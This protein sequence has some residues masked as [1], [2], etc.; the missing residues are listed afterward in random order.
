MYNVKTI[1][2]KDA[3][4][5]VRDNCYSKLAPD[6]VVIGTYQN[7][8]RKTDTGIIIKEIKGGS[9][10]KGESWLPFKESKAIREIVTNGKIIAISNSTEDDEYVQVFE[11]PVKV[12]EVE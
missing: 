8:K 5:F 1:S 10:L 6:A 12:F 7:N 4:K 3:A 9:V 11:Q 2:A